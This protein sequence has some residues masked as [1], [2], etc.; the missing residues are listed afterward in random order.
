ML[1]AKKVGLVLLVMIG[2]FSFWATS[3]ATTSNQGESILS[4]LASWSPHSLMGTTNSSASSLRPAEPRSFALVFSATDATRAEAPRA[5]TQN[6]GSSTSASTVRK[7]QE[8]VNPDIQPFTDKEKT[9]K[10]HLVIVDAIMYNGEPVVLVRL[11]LLYPHVDRF[12]ITE[13][14]MTHSGQDKPL[15]SK[16]YKEQFTPYEDKITWLVYQDPPKY[17][18]TA[19]DTWDREHLQR[20]FAVERIKQDVK[21]GVLPQ[22][23]VILNTDADEL[24]NPAIIQEFQP[25]N[26]LYKKVVKKPLYLEMTWLCYNAKWQKATNWTLGHTLPGKLMVSGDFTLQSY[27][28]HKIQKRLQRHV[29]PNAGWHLTYFLSV[30]EIKRKLESFAHQ[31]YNK[32]RFKSPQHIENCIQKGKDLFL[33]SHWVEQLHPFDKLDLLPLPIKRVHEQVIAQQQP[34]ERDESAILQWK[35]ENDWT[36]D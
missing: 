33:R 31:E 36:G 30:A 26:S 32:P 1:I 20:G 19:K 27:R 9:D 3:K 8:Q 13:S 2:M 22:E 12:Y 18:L 7:D 34:Q 15:Y 14:N 29:V 28:D 35:I 5:A 10:N 23:F 21:D 25:G 4:S 24:P 6:A 16:V 17:N 11:E